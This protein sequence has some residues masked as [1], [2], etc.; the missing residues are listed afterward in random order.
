MG[1]IAEFRQTLDPQYWQTSPLLERLARE[2]K[3][4][5]LWQAEQAR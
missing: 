2:G 5:A 3:T 1:K 4:F